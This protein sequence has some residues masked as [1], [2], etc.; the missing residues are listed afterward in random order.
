M[1]VI[2]MKTRHL[3]V[4]IMMI[5]I[6]VQ[7]FGQIENIYLTNDSSMVMNRIYAGTLSG[8][9]FSMDSLYNTNFVN[10]RFGAQATYKM[11]KTFSFSIWSFYQVDKQAFYA[12]SLNLK[13][14]PTKQWDI[15]I[16][17]M[18][19]LAT[20]QRPLPVTSSGQFETW[21]QA[22]GPNGALG[23]KS[24]YTFDNNIGFGAGFFEREKQPEYQAD[25]IV[26]KFRITGI[27]TKYSDQFALVSSLFLNRFYTIIVWK[28]NEVLANTSCITL[29][30]EKNIEIYSDQGIDLKTNDHI[31]GEIG[32]L[33]NFSSQWVKGKIGG[34]YDIKTNMLIC[35]L[36]VHL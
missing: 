23:I 24:S 1:E 27:Y 33:K 12:T 9:F 16:G 35:Y 32:I 13:I 31:R 34:G 10:V 36:F 4:A 17:K 26:K 22:R 30:K 25:L 20:E 19:T 11:N 7:G 8:T 6:S 14:A 15:Q 21:S 3:I 5:A 2:K 18:A 29:G 28:Q